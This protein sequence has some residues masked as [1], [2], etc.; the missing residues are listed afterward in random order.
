MSILVAKRI[1]P[2]SPVPGIV[3]TALLQSQNA[4]DGHREQTIAVAPAIF[5]ALL[6]AAE[7]SSGRA[8]A[9][10]RHWALVA[11]RSIQAENRD[12]WAEICDVLLRWVAEVTCPSPAEVAQKDG[13]GKSNAA[14]LD[15]RI[16]CHL[17]GTRL[18]MGVPIR[19]HELDRDDLK[20]HVPSLLIGKLCGSAADCAAVSAI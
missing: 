15:E 5:R 16:G 14:R 4:Q 2:T 11:L 1:P 12:A 8:Q 13:A 7:E 19:L 20:N 10:A 3:V 18:V 17:A 9:S 6:F